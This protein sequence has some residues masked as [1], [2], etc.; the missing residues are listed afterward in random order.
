MDR[1]VYDS[2][3]YR[4]SRSAYSIQCA[5]EYFVSLLLCDAYLAK[6]LSKIGISEAMIGVI[7]SLISFAFLFELLS[8]LLNRLVRNA[9][10]TVIIFDTAS[11]L[12]FLFTYLIPFLDV[13]PSMRTVLVFLSVG[14]GYFMKYLI[15]G[16]YWR[17][18]NSFVEPGKR[19]RYNALK[20]MISLASGI[21]FTLVTGFIVDHYEAEGRLTESFLFLAIVLLALACANFFALSGISKPAAEDKN[22]VRR[23][24]RPIL[25][26]T[27]GNRRFL[28]VLLMQAVF[29]I[30]LYFAYGFLGTYKTEDLFFSV[31]TVQLINTAGCLARFAL[32]RPLGAYSDRTSFVKG[33]QLGLIMMIAAFVLAALTSPSTRLLIIV[34]TILYNAAWAGIYA[35]SLNMTYSFVPAEYY[36]EADAIRASLCGIAGFLSSLAASRLMERIQADGNTFLGLSL[37]P[38]QV[39]SAIAVLLLTAAYLIARFVVGRQ[40]VMKQ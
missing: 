1:S 4:H 5:L 14:G 16:I 6:V 31:G 30:G 33:Y 22:D 24:F 8:I 38:Q 26:A 32:S 36:V 35:N 20:E 34:F 29:N 7:S 9:K 11:I 18:A 39:L 15:A 21:V 12:L 27:L 10:R 17:W 13:S 25:R 28:Y 23:S 2:R 37:Y 40:S 3:D 19:G